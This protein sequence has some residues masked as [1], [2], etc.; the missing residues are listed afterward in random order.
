[1][2]SAKDLR[3]AP[4]GATAA[5]DLVRRYHYSGKP[6]NNSRLH[7]GVFWKGKAE[8][9]MSFGNSMKQREMLPLVEGTQWT[10]AME[11]N[12][13]AFSDRLPRNSESRSL[14]IAFR[15]IKGSYPWIEWIVSF[16]DACQCGDGTIYR[17]SGFHLIDIKENKSLYRLPDGRVVNNLCM[18]GKSMLAELRARP[19]ISSAW[20]YQKN[21]RI[22]GAV[23]AIGFQLKYI[24]FLNPAARERLTVPILPFSKIDEMGAS[25]YRGQSTRPKQ[26]TPG[27]TSE[28][29]GQNRPG[30]SK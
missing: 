16:S 21:A 9:V 26:A 29:A 24:Y 23:P 14:S 4:I 22:L 11:L 2:G 28:A 3:V 18:T 15:L 20:S 27:S 8:G 6:V 17:A 19:D 5:R 1:M 12:R 25:M 10:G 13:M 7:L 30:R